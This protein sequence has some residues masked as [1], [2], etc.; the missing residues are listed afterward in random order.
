MQLF[1]LFV[2]S[3]PFQGDPGAQGIKGDSGPKGEPVSLNTL[4]VH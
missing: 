1:Y 4:L 2:Y 3:T